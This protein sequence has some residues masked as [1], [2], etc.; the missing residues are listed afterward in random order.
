MKVNVAVISRVSALM[1]SRE[2]RDK[3]ISNFEICSHDNV[4]NFHYALVTVE[5]KQLRK[6]KI[7]VNR[8]TLL[9]HDRSYL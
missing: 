1:Y 7:K 5:C 8:P 4:K 6:P 3:V 2:T 9:L